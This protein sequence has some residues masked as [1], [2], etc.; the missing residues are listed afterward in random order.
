MSLRDR[1]EKFM[2]AE[3]PN[4]KGHKFCALQVHQSSPRLDQNVSPHTPAMHEAVEK[5]HEE[6]IIYS[7]EESQNVDLTTENV[8]RGE[9]TGFIPGV[10]PDQKT[11]WVTKFISDAIYKENVILSLALCWAFVTLLT[12]VL[13]QGWACG[14]FGPAFL[15]LQIITRTD[16]TEASG[17]L[18]S[19]SVGYLAGS[20]ITGILFDRFSKLLLVSIFPFAGAV[21]SAVLPWCF[22]YELMLAVQFFGGF[23]GG[24]IDASGNALLMYIWGREGN[25]FMQALHFSFAFGGIL[26]PLA[27]S[28]F[29]LDTP[30]DSND[31]FTTD[32]TL[33]TPDSG[34]NINVSYYT[35]NTI[36]NSSTVRNVIT[37][38]N[39]NDI[40]RLY[41]AYSLTAGMHL[42][43]A[44]PL[45]II[46]LR[47]RKPQR[48]HIPKITD[49]DDQ[50]ITREH[51]F[52]FKILILVC[53]C[54]FMAVY[55]AMEETFTAYLTSFCV[56]Q[57]AWS[58]VQGSYATSLY[59]AVFGLAR[60]SGIWVAKYVSPTKIICVLTIVLCVDLG[61]LYVSASFSIDGGIWACAV[62]TGASMSLI[63]PCLIMLTEEKLLPVSGK[64]MSLFMLSSSGGS[65]ANPIILGYLI[66]TFTP[67]WFTYLLFGESV[68]LIILFLIL[69]LIARLSDSRYGTSHS[70]KN[71]IGESNQKS[72]EYV[73]E[74]EKLSA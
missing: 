50:R 59:W 14:Q 2:L 62:F 12:H 52:G 17:F 58:K 32:D 41:I 70:H 11:S 69:L 44:I 51:T 5:Y 7:K 9:K 67:M 8:D 63:Y 43:C 42:S 74:R 36:I 47:S 71:D 19:R 49:R 4:G 65:T 68:L 48:N 39:D 54:L 55:C 66:E 1:I 16:V 28:P 46:Y 61:A 25:S 13:L 10:P 57:L 30:D 56:T 35:N 40:S 37:F 53:L 22:R 27:T 72:N 64:V 18:T 73:L 21:I 3:P 34:Y 29:L 60:F 15:D 26:S 38:D 33:F 31:T 24:G 23:Y 20:V 6:N 45:F